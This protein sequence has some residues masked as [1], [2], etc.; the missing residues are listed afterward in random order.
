MVSERDD[1]MDLILI[2]Q[3][4]PILTLDTSDI[5]KTSRKMEPWELEAGA[6]IPAIKLVPDKY[7]GQIVVI[8]GSAQGIGEATSK[9]FSAQGALV[10]LVDIQE[11]KLKAVQA[12]IIQAGAPVD[13][14]TYRICNIADEK[15]VDEMVAD[16]IR[17]YGKIDI[18]VQLAA[19]Y[20]FIPLIGHPSKAF[21]DVMNVNV[22]ACFY[23][24]RAVLPHM[25]VAGY[26][27]L[28]N[29]ASGTLQLP[30]PGLSAYIT[31][32][33]AIV[34]FTRAIAVEAGP[35]ITANIILPGL[36]RTKAVWKLHERPDGT[37]GL[38][39]S[40]L[41]KQC[42]KR[43][44]RPEDIA[45]AIDFLASPEAQFVTGQILDCGGG[46]TFH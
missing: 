42:V 2:N 10:V 27:R 41:N 8:T 5:G 22:N 35:G 11:D 9:L 12:D 16:I 31:S 39:D 17:S 1:T 45:H 43:N 29:T 32:K 24:T 20:P 44:G 14:I 6:N 15:Q 34:G 3:F 19:L 7:Q 30:D 18:L 40:I 36:V 28:I 21:L 13:S 33:G 38:F 26:G 37:H 4:L 25:Q 46:A 23:L